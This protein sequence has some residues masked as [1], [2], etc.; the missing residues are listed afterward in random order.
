MAHVYISI[1]SNLDDPVSQLRRAIEALR[2]LGV[3]SA[4][5]PFYQTKPWG[6]NQDQPDFINAVV[7]LETQFEPQD[8]LLQLKAAEARL[9]R[10]NERERYSPRIIDFDIL[11]YDDRT[12]DEPDLKIPHPHM[13][14]R[15]F[16]LVPLADLNGDFVAARD[17]LPASERNTVIKL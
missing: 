3:V 6:G 4:V 8:L 16:V 5:S 7:A 17:A 15:A 11:T 9:G 2:G 10:G 14:E 12:V 1:G 13:S